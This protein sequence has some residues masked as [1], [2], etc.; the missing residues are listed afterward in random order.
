MKINVGTLRTRG[1][2]KNVKRKMRRAKVDVLGL[3][4]VR[5]TG[6]GIWRKG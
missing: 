1:K 2:L 3:S 6:V 5:W 4:E